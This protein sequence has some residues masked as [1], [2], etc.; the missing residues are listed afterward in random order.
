M[1]IK[2]ENI[3]YI[4]GHSESLVDGRQNIEHLIEE[5]ELALPHLD[6]EFSKR[7]VGKKYSF[8]KF[9]EYNPYFPDKTFVDSTRSTIPEI[10]P[11]TLMLAGFLYGEGTNYIGLNPI[12]NFIKS[13]NLAQRVNGQTTTL[14]IN[15]LKDGY[16]IKAPQDKADF[17]L[18]SPKRG[19]IKRFPASHMDLS[20]KIRKVS[21]E[22]LE[23][24]GFN[25]QTFRTN[26]HHTI[27]VYLQPVSSARELY[28]QEEFDDD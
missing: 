8:L 12:H 27:Y 9:Q 26:Y 25:P 2:P 16:F 10:R 24:D 5:V 6:I 21:V 22:E 18:T 11:D 20:G 23:K 15:V 14:N 4:D 7:K 1:I 19:R 28:E 17:H 3:V 13:I